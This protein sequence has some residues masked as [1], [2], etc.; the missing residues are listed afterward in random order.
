[1]AKCNSAQKVT[2]ETMDIGL[3]DV[4]TGGT[5]KR[6]YLYY[7]LVSSLK[8]ADSVDIVVSFLME[9]GVKMLLSE[10]ANALDRGA[11]IRILTGNYL[12]ITQPSALYLIKRT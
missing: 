5:D 6:M 9:S 11:R 1:M 7:Q 10:L 12:G 8:K 2:S 3:T 4:M